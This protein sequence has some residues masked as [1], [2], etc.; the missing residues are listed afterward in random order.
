[1]GSK[2]IRRC[3]IFSLE[4]S[5]YFLYWHYFCLSTKQLKYFISVILKWH[6]QFRNQMVWFA[7]IHKYCHFFLT[8]IKYLVFIRESVSVDHVFLCLDCKLQ[9][10]II[11]Y[12]WNGN[13]C[14]E[15]F[16]VFALSHVT[17]WQPN[18]WMNRIREWLITIWYLI[19]PSGLS[20]CLLI[21]RNSTLVKFAE[22]WLL[23]QGC[24]SRRDPDVC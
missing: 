9:F 21:S 19:N 17:D 20:V 8:V 24:L 11:I 4:I 5:N 3:H 1:M 22:T 15:S 6:F 12:T 14:Q 10:Y 23:V 16:I 7:V 13:R 2:S 18:V